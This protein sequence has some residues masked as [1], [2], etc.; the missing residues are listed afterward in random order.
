MKHFFEIVYYKNLR[1]WD[2]GFDSTSLA[3]M[4]ASALPLELELNLNWLVWRRKLLKLLTLNWLF[5]T[6]DWVMSKI[7]DFY[8]LLSLKSKSLLFVLTLDWAWLELLDCGLPKIW[9]RL[10]WLSWLASH[11]HR[12]WKGTESELTGMKK[13][14][15]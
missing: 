8:S 13:E 1:F 11:C 2:F 6:P 14:T 15:A 5:L 3:S 12:N 9:N 7:S 4:I 10:P